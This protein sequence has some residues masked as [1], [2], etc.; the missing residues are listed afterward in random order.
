MS[1]ET[2]RHSRANESDA[3]IMDLSE[4]V[5]ALMDAENRWT[6]GEGLEILEDLV[7]RFGET[8]HR[9]RAKGGHKGKNRRELCHDD[10]VS[11]L[12]AVKERFVNK[13]ETLENAKAFRMTVSELFKRHIAGDGRKFGS[14]YMLEYSGKNSKSI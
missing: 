6:I 14:Y 10:Y 4:S 3:R 5:E 12:Q 13:D 8:E 2:L 1:L 9:P 7:S 11:K